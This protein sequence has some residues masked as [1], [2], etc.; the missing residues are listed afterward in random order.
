MPTSLPPIDTSVVLPAS[1]HR[2]A[3]A[4]EAIHKAAYQTPDA[5][6]APAAALAPVAP[7]PESTR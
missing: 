7:Q 1:V 6:P 4:A 2:A 5:P 3:L